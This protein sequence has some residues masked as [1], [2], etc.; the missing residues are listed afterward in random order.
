MP[1]ITPTVS[2]PGFRVVTVGTGKDY[3]TLDAFHTYAN[4][5]DI[6]TNKEIL[7]AEVYENQTLGGG[8]I[9]GYGGGNASYYVLVR[10]VPG[11]DA[12]TLEKENPLAYGT[13]GIE[14][15]VSSDVTREFRPG[16]VYEGLKFRFTG[17]K[18]YPSFSVQYDY[19]GTEATFRK[20]RFYVGSSFA[21]IQI[22]NNYGKATI[23]D[24]LV[25]FAP[26]IS[27]NLIVNVNPANGVKFERNTVARLGT[28]GSLAPDM[29]GNWV[30]RDNVF[31]NMGGAAFPNRA[32][33]FANNISS[34]S[35]DTGN[36]FTIVAEKS[37]VIDEATNFRPKPNGSLIGAASTFAAN[38][39]DVENVSRGTAPNVGAG[40]TLGI[41]PDSTAITYS[42][43]LTA[44]VN[45]LSR[46]RFSTNNGLKD[47]QSVTLS[48]LSTNF[49]ASNSNPIL[50]AANPYVDVDFTF[51]GNLGSRA[52]TVSAS[53][54]PT[55]PNLT[56]SVNVIAPIPADSLVITGPTT[57]VGGTPITLSVTTNHA[58][59][60][61]QAVSVM[62]SDGDG[63][64]FS[65]NPL[66]LNA[67][68][69][70]KDVTYTA[71]EI[72]SGPHTI[73][74]TTTGNLTIAQTTK[75]VNVSAAPPKYLSGENVYHAGVG[76]QFVTWADILAFLNGKD[77]VAATANVT[78]YVHS[79]LNLAG[80]LTLNANDTYRVNIKPAAGLG[81]A[82]LDPG[83]QRFIPTNGVKLTLSGDAE[84]CSGVNI[85]GFILV[86]PTTNRISYG[87]AYSTSTLGFCR[88]IINV[89]NASAN[90][91]IYSG[92]NSRNC[93][94]LSNVIIKHGG[95]GT[96]VRLGD[97]SGNFMHNTLIG[98]DGFTG[99][100]LVTFGQYGAKGNIQGNVAYNAGVTPINLGE[101]RGTTFKGNFTNV[102]PTGNSVSGF[103]YTAAQMF[104]NDASDIRPATGGPLIGTGS[105]SVVSTNDAYNRNY[106]FVPDAGAI[107]LAQITPLPSGTLTTYNGVKG[108]T[109]T[110]LFNTT[111]TPQ[112]GT[113][114]LNPFD[115]G[116]SV[117]GV[118]N[119]G[120]VTFPTSTTCQVQFFSVRPGTY[121]FSGTLT[122][123]GGNGTMT[124][125][126][127]IK[128]L[129]VDGQPIMPKDPGVE[130]GTPP[131]VTS[132]TISPTT[133]SIA[134]GATQ[135]FTSVVN[136]TGTVSQGVIWSVTGVSGATGGSINSSGLFTGP[137][138]SAVTQFTVKATST[139]DSTKFGSVTVTVLAQPVVTPDPSTGSPVYPPASKVALGFKYGPT[140]VEYTGTATGSGVNVTAEELAEA[141]WNY[142]IALSVPKFLAI[143]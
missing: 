92:Q 40:Q 22:G 13:L 74:A 118:T 138:T 85:E 12:A 108:Q 109:I 7:C 117:L 16:L 136:S 75:S 28:A 62:F 29:N 122:N 3:A 97:G 5:V 95:T 17:A 11:L 51:T 18:A 76:Q 87:T 93:S 48:F 119:Y 43:S 78:V 35:A 79:D 106:G 23:T 33:T 49:T 113:A 41:L 54:T 142:Q 72:S 100:S 6:I 91:S 66:A 88:N 31:I 26:T 55:L 116:T 84:I 131:A 94:F 53:G 90:E 37:M 32:G 58:L 140:G 60:D 135:Q 36:G 44:T 10:P 39:F 141:V 24:S 20:C 125:V 143:K 82:D 21:P 57:A 67:A 120:T 121:T 56:L 115:D 15:S 98:V 137:S 101:A 107:Q 38:T 64:V 9:S 123:A 126:P 110:L 112:S 2:S 4:S 45:A 127:Q 68:G 63:G 81:F 69:F 124:G 42:G 96:A 83:P 134:A 129:G 111:Y 128:V 133:A 104:Q 102:T 34:N 105:P 14:I 99:G 73:T 30:V 114:V 70:T 27:T 132:V 52:L 59:V 71:R 61:A 47:G 130:T 1:T 65:P 103:T 139:F 86:I 50:T 77:N 8:G 80:T 89:T 19:G 46:L 25:V